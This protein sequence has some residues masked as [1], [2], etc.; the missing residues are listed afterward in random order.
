MIRPWTILGYTCA[1]LCITATSVDS[2]VLQPR[3]VGGTDGT[4]GEIPFYGA[5]YWKTSDVILCGGSLIGEEWF[6]TAGHCLREDIQGNSDRKADATLSVDSVNYRFGRIPSAPDSV[7]D[8]A[9]VIIHKDFNAT[10]KGENDIA[11]VR[12][13]KKV[14]LTENV[15]IA[16]IY[17]GEVRVNDKLKVAGMGAIDKVSNEMSAT[18]KTLALTIADPYHCRRFTSLYTNANGPR[19]CTTFIEERGVCYGDGGGPLYKEVA[20]SSPVLV[21]VISTRGYIDPMERNI[22]VPKNGT[23]FFT[24]AYY[25]LDWISKTTNVPKDQLLDNP[26]KN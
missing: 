8:A 18:L 23:N 21:G 17:S 14:A 13:Q 20:N 22:C 6:L 15:Q 16:K 25:Y 19:M 10:G 26:Q 7:V 2:K 11:L 9:E 12:L 24:H 1:I 5:I 4:V 3:I